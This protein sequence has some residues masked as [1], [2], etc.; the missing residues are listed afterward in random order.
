VD[1]FRKIASFASTSWSQFVKI[2]PLDRNHAIACANP[3]LA[4]VEEAGKDSIIEAIVDVRAKDR[5]SVVKN[6]QRLADS[7]DVSSTIVLAIKNVAE[8]SPN[9]RDAIVD[10]TL[11]LIDSSMGMI[12]KLTLLKSIQKIPVGKRQRLIS[13]INFAGMPLQQKVFEIHLFS[14]Q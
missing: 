9:E 7:S 2:L 10:L 4:M 1:F 14:L 5:A 3:L 13:S 6:V 8:I 12:N 11:P